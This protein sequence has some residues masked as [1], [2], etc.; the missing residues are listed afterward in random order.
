MEEKLRNEQRELDLKR[1]KEEEDL[2][3]QLEYEKNR[4]NI[5][6]WQNTKTN[7]REILNDQNIDEYKKDDFEGYVYFGK[8]VNFVK[9]G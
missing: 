2:K 7:Q 6:Y 5:G 1:Q 3:K 8:H 9:E 4:P